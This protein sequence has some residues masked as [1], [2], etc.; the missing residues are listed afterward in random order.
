MYLLDAK[1]EIKRLNDRDV[2]QLE[3]ALNQ[4]QEIS[5]LRNENRILREQLEGKPAT[6]HEQRL[7]RIAK[8]IIREYECQVRP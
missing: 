3:Q 4:L 8:G 7:L 2:H 1:N 6:E 5:N